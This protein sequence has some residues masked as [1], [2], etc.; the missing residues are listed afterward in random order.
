MVDVDE[1][2]DRRLGDSS[3]E[4]DVFAVGRC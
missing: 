3:D 4:V 2:V 1:L